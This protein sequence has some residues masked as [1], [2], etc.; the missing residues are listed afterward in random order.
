MDSQHQSS[1]Q[2][3][4][5]LIVKPVTRGGMDL[6]FLTNKEFRRSFLMLG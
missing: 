3:Q 2:P 4:R 5:D 1:S 6:E